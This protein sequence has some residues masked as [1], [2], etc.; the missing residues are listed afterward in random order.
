MRMFTYENTRAPLARHRACLRLCSGPS[1]LNPGGSRERVG[2]PAG[3]ELLLQEWW[4]PGPP[5]ASEGKARI[6][7]KCVCDNGLYWSP[8]QVELCFH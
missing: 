1:T 8:A 7:H 3:A 5:R 6:T 2:L 4:S